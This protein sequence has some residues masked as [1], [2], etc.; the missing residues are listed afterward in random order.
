MENFDRPNSQI[1]DEPDDLRPREEQNITEERDL[2]EK[3]CQLGCVGHVVKPPN[4]ELVSTLTR[5]AE[6]M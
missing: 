2:E 3:C 4:K 6:Q 1:V 5:V